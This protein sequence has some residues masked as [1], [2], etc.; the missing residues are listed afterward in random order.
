MK[1]VAL[2]YVTVSP[3]RF[4]SVSAVPG[5]GDSGGGGGGVAVTLAGAPGEE[6]TLVYVSPDDKVHVQTVAVAAN[7]GWGGVLR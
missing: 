1:I 5:G 2:K 6:V 7:D 4:T 3:S